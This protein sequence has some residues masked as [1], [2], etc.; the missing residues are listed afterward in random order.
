[1][2]GRARPIRSH[3]AD[4]SWQV[5]S[6]RIV[7]DADL[8][9]GPTSSAIPQRCV[10]TPGAGDFISLVLDFVRPFTTFVH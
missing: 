10:V 2:A 8:V 6:E 4:A 3:F 9:S 7:R 5:I 1:M